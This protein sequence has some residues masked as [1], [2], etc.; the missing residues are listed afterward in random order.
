M[1]G[2]WGKYGPGSYAK[3]DIVS[4]ALSFENEKVQVAFTPMPKFSDDKVFVDTEKYFF[5]TDGVIF[6]I[7]EMCDSHSVSRLKELIPLMYEQKGEQFFNEFRGSFS[8]VFYDKTN[9]NLLIYNDHIGDRMIFYVQV[10][11]TFYFST[12]LKQLSESLPDSFERKI[13]DVFVLSMLSYGYSPN[14]QTLIKGINRVSAGCYLKITRN[15]IEQI[16]YHRFTNFPNTRTEKENVERLDALFRQAVR[17]ILDKNKQYGYRNVMPLSAGLDSRMTVWVARQLS[18]EPIENV[19]YSQSGYYDEITPKEIAKT[20][21]NKMHFKPLD[22][23]NYLKNVDRAVQLTSGLVNYSGAAQVIDSFDDL[24]DKD[25][26][27]VIA[28]GML[29]DIIVGTGYTQN[30]VN[31]PFKFGDGALSKKLLP[32][33]R[34]TADNQLLENFP[35]R[36]IYYLYVRGF[37]CANLGSPLVFQEFTESFSPFYDTDL[38]EFA[39]TIP[40]SQR[41]GNEIYDHWILTKYPEAARWK[42]NGERTIGKKMRMVPI[43]GK[44]IPLKD[45]PARMAMFVLKKTRIHN[46]DKLENGRSMNPIDSWLAGNQSLRE[47][48]DNYFKANIDKCDKI[49]MRETISSF[50]D[51]GTSFEKLQVISLLA[52]IRYLNL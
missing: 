11:D 32:L 7:A 23:G 38:L 43:L 50:Y 15:K 29:G 14:C 31:Q 27:G 42:H 36:E 17:R 26:I 10:D 48:I 22:G 35:N 19:T 44:S 51:A 13:D 18:Y 45:L 47:Y 1:F 25:T 33:L 37:N 16:C 4:S 41:F 34:Q 9:D 2:Y 21:G 3:N 40:L 24:S 5:L 49:G 12:D 8:G 20:L 6:N 46:Y 39:Y 52:G 30:D 28:T